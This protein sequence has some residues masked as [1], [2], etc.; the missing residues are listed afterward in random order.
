MKRN[1]IRRYCQDRVGDGGFRDD[2]DA[3]NFARELE[4]V[5]AQTYDTEF[6]ELMMANGDIIPI[7]GTVPS[8][9]QTYTYYSYTP[10]G[11]SRVMNTYA[12]S[13]IPRVGLGA[14]KNSGE[15]VSIP[16]V[17]GFNLQDERAGAMPGQKYNLAT[18]L[19]EASKRATQQE[20]NDIGW[21][22]NTEHNI[23]GMLTHPN[24]THTIT[25]VGG[26]SGQ[27][28]LLLMD[29]DEI[30]AVFADLINTPHIISNG[31]ETVTHVAVA[32][33]V[34]ADLNRPRSTTSDTSIRQ[35]LMDNYSDVT[36]IKTPILNTTQ[37]DTTGEFVG[38]ALMVAYTKRAGK[39][40]LV[41][42]Q[43]YEQRPP[44]EVGL[45]TLI[46]THAR[47]GGYKQPYPLS[48]HVYRQI[49]GS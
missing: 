37:H 11:M 48:V 3:L 23:K 16:N 13:S 8:G 35:W 14:K 21:F 17:Y 45:E 6:P 47:C 19:S 31:V 39:G 44:Q 40:E 32:S 12:S 20:I 5:Y 38:E 7:D 27:Q 25:P 18:D 29:P 4:H 34:W 36:F 28:S 26:T 9:A 30:L 24:V 33:E 42:P 46:Y 49:T 43:Q 15:I 10:V 22:G 1:A 2:A 41:I